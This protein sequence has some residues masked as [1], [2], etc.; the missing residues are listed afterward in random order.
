MLTYSSL[1]QVIECAA[2]LPLDKQRKY[3]AMINEAWIKKY[4]RVNSN[5]D[6]MLEDIDPVLTPEE[7]KNL[8][9]RLV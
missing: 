8:Y 5:R 3:A 2:M 6:P 7:V 9:I 1:A 4:D